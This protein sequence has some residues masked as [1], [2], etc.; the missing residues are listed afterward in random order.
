M[1][2]WPGAPPKHVPHFSLPIAV[3]REDVL[4][5]KLFGGG[6]LINTV[7]H[8]LSEMI[9]TLY[10]ADPSRFQIYQ[11]EGYDAVHTSPSESRKH[12]RVNVMT[13]R[14]GDGNAAKDTYTTL[15]IG[16]VGYAWTFV[17]YIFQTK[18]KIKHRMLLVPEPSWAAKGD[19]S[20]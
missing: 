12:L 15:H 5:Q 7:N 4:L 1:N 6:L 13:K 10:H 18:D 20:S 8:A 17:D 19:Y 11:K 16:V 14:A 9:C 2:D 3:N